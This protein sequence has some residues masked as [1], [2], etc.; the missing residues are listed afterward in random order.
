MNQWIF[1]I[2]KIIIFSNDR[3]LIAMFEF[4]CRDMQ[5]YIA[6]TNELT[7]IPSKMMIRVLV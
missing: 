2:N 3:S 1:V 7:Q 6:K 4:L 5:S